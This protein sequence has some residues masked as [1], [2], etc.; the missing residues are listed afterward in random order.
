MCETTEEFVIETTEN[1]YVCFG[2]REKTNTFVRHANGRRYHLECY[3]EKLKKENAYQEWDALYQYVRNEIMKYPETVSLSRDMVLRLKGLKEGIFKSNRKIK[4]LANY[5]F[6]HILYTFKFC[7]RDIEWALLNTEFNNES[8]KFNFIMKIVERN[9][10]DIALRDLAVKKAQE[11]TE[12][13]NT[14]GIFLNP[15]NKSSYVNKSKKNKASD[16]LKH[17]W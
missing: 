8:H 4:K 13:I 11:K 14:D 12:K 9:L 6:K 16:K 2:C 5:E 15:E 17:L 1:E 10:N 3:K 7:K